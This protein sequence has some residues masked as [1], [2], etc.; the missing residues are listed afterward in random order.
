MK[1]C[2]AGVLEQRELTDFILINIPILALRGN[3]PLVSPQKT[4]PKR[5]A[6]LLIRKCGQ[7]LSPLFGSLPHT[8]TAISR[9]LSFFPPLRFLSAL[10]SSKFLASTWRRLAR[11]LQASLGM[12]IPP[13]LALIRRDG[14]LCL[15]GM[16]SIRGHITLQLIRQSMSI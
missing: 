11:S 9:Q 4:G 5:R 15:A 1:R 6:F 10:N 13:Q 14:R 3:P 7:L 16:D 12:M 8:S 2:L